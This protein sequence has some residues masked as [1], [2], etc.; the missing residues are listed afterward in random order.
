MSN[1]TSFTTNYWFPYPLA[2]DSISLIATRMQQL[3]QRI[4]D[5]Y[6][7]LG[8]SYPLTGPGNF[9][10]QEGDAAGGSLSGTYPNPSIANAV[11]GTLNLIDGSVTEPKLASDSVSTSKIQ[12]SAVTTVKIDN[13][14]VTNAKLSANSVT[15]DKIVDGTIQAADLASNSVT[16]AKI[17]DNQITNAKMADNSVGTSDLINASVTEPKLASNSVSTAKIVDANVTSGK[18]QSNVNLAGNPTTTTQ[19]N[20]DNT[21]K[22]A[23]TEFVQDVFAQSQ[24]TQFFTHVQNTTNAHNIDIPNIVYTTDTGTVTSTM[25]L[26]DT[27]VDAD[28]NA[29][30]AIVDTKLDTI[31]TAGKVDNSATTGTETSTPDTLMLRDSNASF[32]A[33]TA[34]L[35]GVQFDILTPA[36]ADEGLVSWSIDDG[37]LVLGLE[38]GHVALPIGQKQVIYAKNG[39]GVTIP[40]M[41][42]V[43][44][45]GAAGDRIDIAPANA[46]GSVNAM[47]ML[48]IAAENIS[49]D[50]L[51]YVVTN[52]Y[53]RNVNTN[54]W[55]VG[56]VLYFDPNTPGG[57]TDTPPTAPEINLPVAI[58]TKKN[59]SSGILY[60]RMKNGEYLDEIH[61]VKID[62][63]TLADGDVLK[64]N[65]AL[66]VWENVIADDIELHAST[67]ELGGTDEVELDP[68]QITGTAVV[69]N[70]AR[71]SDSRTPSGSAGGDLS[72][73]YPNPTLANAGTAGTYTKVTTDAKGRVTSGTT[74]GESDIPSLSPSKITGTAV[75]TT[76]ARLS[77]ARTPTSHASTHEPGAGDAIDVSKFIAQGST[78]PMMPNSLYPAGTLFAV[79]SVAPYLIYRSS[80]AAWDQ[81][82]ASAI[83]VSDNAPSTP[84]AGDLWYESDT[85]K[86]FIFY[87]SF[88]VEMGNNTNASVPLH[89]VEHEFGGADELTIDSRQID[90]STVGYPL[91]RNVIINGAMQVHQRGT[92]VTGITTGGYYTADRW[93]LT[94]TSQGTW[95]KSIEND[96]P[97]GS[98][99]NKSLK[100]L[101]TTADSSPAAND[102]I[103]INTILEGQNLQHFLK[104]TS[105]A[106]KFAVSFWV[107]S[108]VTG[109]YIVSLYD[110][111]NNRVIS[112]TYTINASATWEKKTIVFPADTTGAF[113]VDNARS[114]DLVFAL[115]V[116]SDRSSGTLQTTWATY[117]PA[118]WLV[119]QT[120][121]AA[122][123]NNYWQVTGVQLEP[124]V[125]TPFEFEDYGTTLRKCQRYYHQVT[126]LD[127]GIGYLAGSQG[128]SRWTVFHPVTMR[129]NGTFSYTGTLG[130]DILNEVAGVG[131]TGTITALT[132]TEQAPQSCCIQAQY[133]P[134]PSAG[135]TRIR[136][137]NNAT[138]RFSAEL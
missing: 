83:T 84:Q 21:T 5:T 20:T 87:D 2:S 53:V 88:W 32:E 7:Y 66:G 108:N 127:Y 27:I 36:P 11:I 59:S 138:F 62:P 115:G 43:M 54:A 24:G 65:A 118:N 14:A 72:G 60:V 82:G 58:V 134:A 109:T 39:T 125:V 25:I 3:A 45:I 107:K 15:S 12:A 112:A 1:E 6:G 31:S 22:I 113:D 70:D 94:L 13:N 19:A 51:G 42:A 23:T 40:K 49:D 44:A 97:T 114:F 130:T 116:G 57:L 9:L 80:G 129:T 50:T 90:Y 133:S 81:L 30:A 77:D 92:S 123:T 41:T 79:G 48:G 69:T 18:I 137:I 106:K 8:I 122:A 128:F 103:R 102:Q 73:S 96:A 86:T 99:F 117:V 124:E 119:G 126:N 67:H 64:Y 136:L 63:L 91:G 101:C 17:A 132:A 85:G 29:N 78:L 95:T 71:L 38:G 47:Y 131:N 89:G 37:S 68:T 33:N 10:M 104:G 98:G 76:D 46:D 100:M 16:T 105:A 120:N 74:L 55:N 4:E 75:I 93:S 110:F 26:D 135:A 121:L 111:D 56:T 52:G 28:I 35:Q 34:T 61:D